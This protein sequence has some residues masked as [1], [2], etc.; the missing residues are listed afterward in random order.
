MATLF[1]GLKRFIDDMGKTHRPI[2]VWA[3]LF[4][5]P[6]IFVGAC[7]RV[8]RAACVHARPARCAARGAQRKPDAAA[9][10]ADG[11]ATGG[12][13]S[14][15]RGFSTPAGLVFASRITS[16]FIAGQVALRRPFSKLHGPVM[17]IPFLLSMP[18]C[19]NWLGT[20]SASADP[21]MYYFIAYTSIITS[22]SLV[23]DAHIAM[24]WAGGKD[25]GQYK[26][27]VKGQFPHQP[28]LPLPSLC[29]ALAAHYYSQPE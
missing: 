27:G 29:I 13:L 17:H 19:Y 5:F 21:F 9:A 14:A 26:R 18:F 4:P 15:T 8:R 11:C 25:V 3:S 23:L 7:V 2:A 22:I 28:L 1:V 6:Q 24:E 10:A 16:F 20:A 12:Y